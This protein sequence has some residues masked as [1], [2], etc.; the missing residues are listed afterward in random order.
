MRLV[1][2]R[3]LEC[4][5]ADEDFTCPPEGPIPTAASNFLGKVTTI[6]KERPPLCHLIE[7]HGTRLATHN[8]PVCSEPDGRRN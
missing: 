8:D 3:Q 6:A 4:Q 5:A 2:V 1:I 7:D